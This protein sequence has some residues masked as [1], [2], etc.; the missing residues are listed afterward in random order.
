MQLKDSKN[1]IAELE[2]RVF[3]L[4]SALTATKDAMEKLSLQVQESE[5][6]KQA[7]LA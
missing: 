4:T 2:Q 5:T 6:N 7:D 3:D 1:C